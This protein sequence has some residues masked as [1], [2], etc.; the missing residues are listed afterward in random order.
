MEVCIRTSLCGR[1]FL[2][3]YICTNQ[4]HPLLVAGGRRERVALGDVL[5]FV[6]GTDEEP[7]L[8]FKMHP[9]IEF[10]ENSLFYPSANTCVNWLKLVRGSL[11]TPLPIVFGFPVHLPY[12]VITCARM[13]K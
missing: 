11:T 13:V 4:Q 3:M 12:I 6:T 5:R 2:A 1:C 9:S 8:G 10:C 7:V